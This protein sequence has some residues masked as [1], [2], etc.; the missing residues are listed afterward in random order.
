MTPVILGLRY[1]AKSFSYVI[2]KFS[3]SGKVI[4]YF[5]GYE[6]TFQLYYKPNGQFYSLFYSD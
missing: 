6:L 2:L 3:L 5:T 1:F 4:K